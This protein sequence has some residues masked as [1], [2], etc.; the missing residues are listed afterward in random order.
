MP[1]VTDERLRELKLRYN[2]AHS[3]YQGRATALNEATTSGKRPSAE[4]LQT[5]AAALRELADAR[6]KLL[7]ALRGSG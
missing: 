6:A 4:L 7:A 1:P 2:A 3:A 5:E